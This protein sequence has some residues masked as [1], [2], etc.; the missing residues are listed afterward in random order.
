M[1]NEFVYGL[2]MIKYGV[3]GHIGNLL[4]THYEHDGNAFGWW[5]LDGNT[6]ITWKSKK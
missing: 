4:G 5:Q 3:M 1:P 6:L 2:F